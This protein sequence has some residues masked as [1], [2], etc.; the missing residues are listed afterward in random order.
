MP[1]KCL[2]LNMMLEVMVQLRQH[3]SSFRRTKTTYMTFINCSGRSMTE[4]VR[5]AKNEDYA[6][7]LV[8]WFCQE[9]LASIL[10]DEPMIKARATYFS[11]H[12]LRTVCVSKGSY[13]V[14]KR[15]K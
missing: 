9:R 13:T 12:R 11:T 10:F 14:S 2:D 4:T 6:S 8:E 1:M 5:N 3:C 7:A 15:E